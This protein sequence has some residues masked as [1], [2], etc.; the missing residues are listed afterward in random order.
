MTEQQYNA[1]RLFLMSSIALITTAMTFAIR[2]S[3]ENVWGGEFDLTSTQM[4][5]AIGTA[6]W[7]FTL[8]QFVGGPLVDLLGMKRFVRIAFFLHA[9]GIIV[10]I[11]AGGFWI[12]FIGTLRHTEQDDDHKQHSAANRRQ[13]FRGNARTG[14]LRNSLI[15]PAK[16]LLPLIDG[17]RG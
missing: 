4:A 15:D 2:A 13:H 5:I 12:L 11:I 6:F 3:L 7:G 8:A 10:T 17:R 1:K 16:H 14:K 9:I